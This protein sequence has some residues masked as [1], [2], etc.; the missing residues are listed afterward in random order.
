MISKMAEKHSKGQ[1]NIASLV[2][3]ATAAFVTLAIAGI[4]VAT[5]FKTGEDLVNDSDPNTSTSG[6]SLVESL[7]VDVEDGMVQLAG[8][9]VLIVV[10]VVLGFLRRRA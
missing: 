7:Q 10:I 6:E 3:A 5:V 8:L 2:D 4:V 9:I 1:M